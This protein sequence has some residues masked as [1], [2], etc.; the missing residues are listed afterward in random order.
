LADRD[1]ASVKEVLDIN[2][3]L[4][5]L[6]KEYKKALMDF[7][8]RPVPLPADTRIFDFMKWI[9]IEFS[10]PTQESLIS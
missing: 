4:K 10:L 7:G 9:D 8:V 1:E 3:K 5:L 2:N 6:F